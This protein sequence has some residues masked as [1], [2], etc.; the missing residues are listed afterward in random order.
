MSHSSRLDR[1]CAMVMLNLMSCINKPPIPLFDVPF[2]SLTVCLNC[3]M[4]SNRA[5]VISCTNVGLYGTGALEFV[6]R[7]ELRV[8]EIDSFDVADVPSL[9]S[10]DLVGSDIFE[11]LSA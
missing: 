9:W 10:A 3:V 5:S 4:H 11:I 7:E 2:V 1:A 6:R 8:M